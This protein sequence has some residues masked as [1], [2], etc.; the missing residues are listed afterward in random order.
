MYEQISTYDLSKFTTASF[1]SVLHIS[2]VW[3]PPETDEHSSL[4][5]TKREVRFLKNRERTHPNRS[6]LLELLPF[7]YRFRDTHVVGS[8]KI[9]E[10][11]YWDSK[12]GVNAD[13]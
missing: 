6:L 9:S 11:A 7:H 8:L 2:P 5:S 10:E 4:L 1:I 12:G 3:L 13:L